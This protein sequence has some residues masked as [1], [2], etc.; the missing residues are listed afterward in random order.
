V[1]AEALFGFGWRPV[2]REAIEA[3]VGPTR[4]NAARTEAHHGR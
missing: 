1:L 4:I 3:K 2:L